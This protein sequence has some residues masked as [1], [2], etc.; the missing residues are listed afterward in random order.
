MYSKFVTLLGNLR[1]TVTGRFY[2]QNF[3]KVQ[4]IIIQAILSQNTLKKLQLLIK[5][6]FVPVRLLTV[7]NN[8]VTS[9]KRQDT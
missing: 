4:Y 2:T 1:M 6:Y 5:I 9:G 8:S 7:K 3:L